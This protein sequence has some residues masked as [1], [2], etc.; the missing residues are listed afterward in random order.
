MKNN[1]SN[2]SS[3]SKLLLLLA[4]IIWGSAFVFQKEG[5]QVIGAFAFGGIRFFI[6][7]SVLLPILFFQKQSYYQF[8]IKKTIFSGI[9][10]GSVLF[11]ATSAQQIGINHTTVGKAGFITGFYMILTPILGILFK[12]KTILN[13]WIGAGLTLIGLYL[14]SGKI[15][16][17]M[18][19]GDFLVLISTIFWALQIILISKYAP[20]ANPILLSIVEFYTCSILSLITSG[21]AETT[22]ISNVIDA[23]IPILFTGV[24]ST[25]IAFTLQVVAQKNLPATPAAIIFSSETLFA[26]LAGWILLNEKMGVVQIIGCGFMLLG[27]IFGQLNFSKFK[28]DQNH[29]ISTF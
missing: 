10:I 6:G 26:A 17:S 8:P 25:G 23:I 9:L 14:L 3:K 24:L 1:I 27:I 4:A 15:D 7:A 19:Y 11:L 2:K 12:Q 18:G 21:F 22:S 5:G 20:N 29:E 13:H 16:F 28:N